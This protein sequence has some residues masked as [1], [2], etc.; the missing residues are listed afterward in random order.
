MSPDRCRAHSADASSRRPSFRPDLL[1][2]GG[3]AHRVAGATC[4]CSRAEYREAR[5][6]LERALAM[7]PNSGRG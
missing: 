6:H 2:A 1:E 4:W 7:I 5:D 3:V